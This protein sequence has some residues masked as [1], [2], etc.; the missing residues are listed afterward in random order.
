MKVTT[1]SRILNF[2]RKNQ[3]ATADEL[4]RSLD[5]TGANIRHHLANMEANGQ[6]IVISR[7]VE[8][9]GRPT[10]VYAISNQV[11]DNGLEDLAEAVME[12]WLM[13]LKGDLREKALRSIA[14]RLAG[15]FNVAPATSIP[16]KMALAVD[17]LNTL[18]YQA[19]WEAGALG[20]RVILGHCPYAEIIDRHPELCRM[21]AYLLEA[22]LG[23]P[24]RQLAKMERGR[25]GFPRCVFAIE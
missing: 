10:N 21:D 22:Q 13:S 20:A 9:R 14:A 4:G 17:R 24:A 12:A 19:R 6:L 11:L 5:M 18:H 16:R 2:L 7:R 25:D 23:L 8:G 3:V 15:S 1:Q